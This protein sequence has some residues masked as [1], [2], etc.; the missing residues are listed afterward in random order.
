MS[1]LKSPNKNEESLL[2]EKLQMASE[3]ERV[4]AKCCGHLANLIKN[5]RVRNKFFSISEVARTNEKLLRNRLREFGENHF[6]PEERCKYCK[7]EPES[8]SLFGALN[9]GVE[10]T[11]TVMAHYKNLVA[12]AMTS[13]DK[14]V[15]KELLR[16]K[17][18]QK[19]FLKKE[20]RFINEKEEKNQLDCIGNYCIPKIISKI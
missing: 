15:F 16:E 20:L 13:K 4:I 7:V 18:G 2:I 17:S 14:K 9:L 5:G 8:F 12:L 11:S 19:H 3:A 6:I 10:I 1:R